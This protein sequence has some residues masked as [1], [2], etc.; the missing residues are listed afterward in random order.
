MFRNDAGLTPGPSPAGEGGVRKDLSG[1]GAL[2]NIA[3]ALGNIAS[4]LGNIAS[5][6]GNI[7]SA[8]GNIASALG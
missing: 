2:R 4:A 1:A 8:L 7:A 6:L 3:S 5:A